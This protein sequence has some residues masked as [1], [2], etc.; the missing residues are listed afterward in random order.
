MC[1]DV[2]ADERPAG[3]RILDGEWCD[4]YLGRWPV[5]PGYCYVIWKGRH[6]AEPTEL[7]AEESFGFWR[8]VTAVASAIERR[9]RPLKMNWLSLGN[10]VPHLH[11]HLVPRH[12]DDPCAGGPLEQDAFDHEGQAPLDDATLRAEAKALRNLVA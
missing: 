7:S 6:V 1:S 2:G 8:E 3:V 4:G 11:V 10:W 12:A 9:Y 5:R